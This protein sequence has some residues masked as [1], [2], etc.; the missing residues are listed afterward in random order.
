MLA[1]ALDPGT[2]P[3]GLDAGPARLCVVTRKVRPMTELIR[4]VA[5]P[6][7]NVMA[8]LKHKLPGRGV[9]V[10]A[11][12]N[13]VAEAVKRGAFAR[14]LRRPVRAAPDLPDTVEAQFLRA[15]LDALAI[16]QKAGAVAAGFVRVEKALTGPDIAAV[17]HAA[18]AG[19]DGVRKI[20]SALRGRNIR[21]ISGL[22]SA[23]LDL[24]LARSNVVHAALLAGRPSETVLAR[25]DRLEHYRTQPAPTGG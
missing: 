5:A 12:R 15:V 9:W 4:F 14:G 2:E 3:A 1:V 23:Q 7:G 16:A 11:E 20:E 21:V 13:A 22:T 17:L 19:H 8:D 24:A 6:D 25:Y 18:E 10:S